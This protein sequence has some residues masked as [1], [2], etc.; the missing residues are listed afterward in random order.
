MEEKAVMIDNTVFSF[1]RCVVVDENYLLIR[2]TGLPKYLKVIPRGELVLWDI[3]WAIKS[4]NE[5]AEEALENQN[6][7]IKSLR[8]NDYPEY[9]QTIREQVVNTCMNVTEDIEDY[10]LDEKL[11]ML[12][13]LKHKLFNEKN[14][15]VSFARKHNGEVFWEIK[16]IEKTRTEILEDLTTPIV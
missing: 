5:K 10:K 11:K 14:D 1:K 12:C 3:E 2:A 4:I 16:Q 9:Y 6:K 8:A 13:R 15:W 7:R